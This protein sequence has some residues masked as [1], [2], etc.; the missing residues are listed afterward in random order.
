MIRLTAYVSGRVQR[1]G[2]RARVV[3]QALEMDLVGIVQNQPDGSVLVI[4]EG[5]K[6][7][8]LEKFASAIRIENAFIHV[9]DL[10]AKYSQGTGQYSSFKK[11]TG[12]NEVGERL[13]DGI[14]ILKEIVISL[15]NLTVMTKDLTTVTEDGFENLTTITKE[16]FENLGGKIDQTLDKQDETIEEIRGLRVDL[17]SYMDRRFKRIEADL[18]ELKEMKAALKEKGLI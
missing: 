5:E 17:K 13:D 3:S 8:D 7:E 14:E 9:D 10:S 11:I 1:V 2:Y 16:G 6:K 18:A 12:P 15:K 4:A